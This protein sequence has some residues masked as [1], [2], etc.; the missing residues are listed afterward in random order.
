MFRFAARLTRRS[1]PV[2]DDF[3][4]RPDGEGLAAGGLLIVLAVVVATYRTPLVAP[5]VYWEPAPEVVPGLSYT[6]DQ[7]RV[8]V[9]IRRAAWVFDGGSHRGSRPT[10]GRSRGG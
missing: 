4:P 1:R 8:E 10:K 2:A 5:P 7:F 6:L 9:W 3:A